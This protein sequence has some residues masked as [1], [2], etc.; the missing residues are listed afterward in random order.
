M[1]LLF[2]LLLFTFTVLAEI[3]DNSFLIEEAYNQD[4]GVYQFINI[5][6]HD[7]KTGLYYST[8]QGEIPLWSREHQFSFS[9]PARKTAASVESLGDLS[10]NYRYQNY[11]KD[12]TMVAQRFGA[13][14][15]TGKVNKNTSYNSVG[16]AWMQAVTFSLSNQFQ[17]H[18]NLGLNMTPAARTKGYS[19]REMLTGF[20]TGVGIVYKHSDKVNFLTE[21]L[22]DTQEDFDEKGDTSSNPTITINPGARFDIDLSIEKTQVVP[23]I[24]FPVTVGNDEVHTGVLFYLSFEPDFN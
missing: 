16:F 21:F 17:M 13:I 14:V 4:P 5:Y 2:I 1:I 12:G 18:V 9:L 7:F 19:Q 8:L 24:S 6:Q 15:P 10:L 20:T 23:G 3:Q 22:Y 11:N